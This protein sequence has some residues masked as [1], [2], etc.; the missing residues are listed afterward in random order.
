[1]QT[2]TQ[3]TSDAPMS[4]LVPCISTQQGCLLVALAAA[5]ILLIAVHKRWSVLG[6]ISIFGYAVMGYFIVAWHLF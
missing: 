2:S 5:I 1:M 6:T 4:L 3:A